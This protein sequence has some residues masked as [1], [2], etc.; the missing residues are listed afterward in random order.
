MKSVNPG[1]KGMPNGLPRPNPIDRKVFPDGLRTS[2]Q[3]PPIENQLV[4]FEGFPRKINGSTVWKAQEMA[5]D[6]QRW[7]HQ[8]TETEL[9]QL[10]GAVESFIDSGVPLTEI[11][12]VIICS[13]ACL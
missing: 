4:H 13:V 10:L 8:W 9:Q 6:P 11:S 12:K 7:V 3:H 5:D 1:L 2:G